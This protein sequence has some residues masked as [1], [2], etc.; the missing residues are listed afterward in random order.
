MISLRG[1]PLVPGRA[2]GA[3]FILRPT[4]PAAAA[5]AGQRADGSE[6][7]AARRAAA[8]DLRHRLETMP[9]GPAREIVRA[10]IVLIDDP[11][12]TAAI[13]QH[14]QG[15]VGVQAAL[16]EAGAALAARFEALADPVLRT[17]ADDLRDVCGC[18]ARHLTGAPRT[19]PFPES[20]VVCAVDLSPTEVLQLADSRPLGFVLERGAAA[21]HAAILMRALGVPAVIR[22]ER[23]TESVNDGDHVLIDGDSGQVVI[24]PECIA[25]ATSDSRMPANTC[26]SDP[27]P[28]VTAD[29]VSVAI[30]ATM[31]GLPDLR[32]AIAAGADGIGLFRTEWLFLSGDGIPSEQAQFEIYRDVAELSETRTITIRTIDLG[33]DKHPAALQLPA[34]PNPALGLRG[35]RFALAYPDLLR[36]QLRALLH[37]FSGRRVRVLLPMVNDPG[38][39]A[40]VRELLD[41][42]AGASTDT[43]VELGAMIE[44]PAAAVM[45]NEIAEVVDFLSIGTND[46]TQY[47]LA[48][49]RE[50]SAPPYE[51]LHPAVLRLVQQT[52]TA[53]KRHR[54]SLIVCGDAA[55]DRHMTPLLIGLGVTGLSVAPDAIVRTKRLVRAISA[56][57]AAVLAERL[58]A[59]PT[60]AAVVAQL[61]GLD[62][63]HIGGDVLEAGD[64]R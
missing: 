20:R 44:T 52:A 21:S 8:A 16:S 11:L 33:G 43:T 27:A 9:D 1:S 39:V 28:A 41:E 47:V 36:T 31:A 7:A 63:S 32:R 10:H 30:M 14:L 62:T 5:P 29:G 4:A 34:E 38:D 59:L 15:G 57:S 61:R 58:L 40:R 46:L 60:A 37:A 25:I 23:A 19:A 55:S 22:V 12:L 50:G 48:A 49:D 42:A 51:P 45:A 54:R 24:H 2:A 3:A 35:V 26:E 64:A 56:A 18:I 53:A 13:E 17:R 6:I